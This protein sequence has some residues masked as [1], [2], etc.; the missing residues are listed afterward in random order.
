M[1]YYIDI[2]LKPDAEMPLNRILNAVYTKLHKAL[3]DLQSS[4][5]GVSFPRY[6]V[7]FGNILRVHGSN[8]DLTKL[9]ELNWLGGMVGYCNV[10]QITN[11][12][13]DAKF[14]TVSRKQTNM[15]QS[16]LKR[17]IKRGSIKDDEIKQYKVKTFTKGLD[18]PYLE[19]ESATN[20]HHH[21]RYI[22]FGELLD[23]PID[24]KFDQFGLSKIATVPWF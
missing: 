12:P 9:V 23:A 13:A 19:L 14:R 6:R 8:Q 1:K 24:G 10:S 17:L 21:R 2:I 20:G 22:E 16:K 4:S 7:T 18:N 15:S 11:V 5:I 3:Y